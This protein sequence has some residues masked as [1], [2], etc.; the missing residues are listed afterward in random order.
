MYICKSNSVYKHERACSACTSY[1]F[2]AL[3]PGVW[4][5]WCW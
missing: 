2:I 1:S 5:L 3:M 4:K